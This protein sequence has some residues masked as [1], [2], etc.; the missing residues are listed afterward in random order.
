MNVTRG[1]VVSK[2][3]LAIL[4]L[5]CAGLAAGQV[6][7]SARPLPSV[8]LAITFDD[9]PAHGSLPPGVTRLEVANKIIAAFRDA[10]LPPVYGFVNGADTEQHPG[11]EDVLK[12]WHEAGNPLGDHTWSHMNLNQHSLDEFEAEVKHNQPVVSKWMEDEDWHWFRFP[13]LAEGDTLEK[14]A[15]IRKFL[16]EQGYKVAT[17]TM[18]F[19]DYQWTEPYARCKAKGDERA[20][21]L[22]K[23]TYLTAAEDSINYYREMSRAL[24]G[25]DIPYVLLMHIGALDAALMPRLLELYKSKGFQFVSLGEAESDEFYRIDTDLSLPP[26]AD[27]LEGLMT[28]RHLTLPQRPTPPVQFATICQ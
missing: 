13:F 7:S 27:T 6:S 18:S 16:H 8:Q 5:L 21:E 20:V 17:V 2:V 26:S 23:S 4:V 25:R 22:L 15:G 11:D 28:E 1:P 12:A 3:F 10:H 14:R 9:L 24:Y 19:G